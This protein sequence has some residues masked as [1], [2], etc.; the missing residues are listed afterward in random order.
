MNIPR[1]TI[2]D[3]PVIRT[4]FRWSSLILL[5]IF[6]WRFEGELPD[7]P[8]YVLIAAPHTS[9]WDLFYTMLMAI[10]KNARIYWFGKN[11]IFYPPYGFFFR[12]LGGISIDRSKPNNVVRQSI[13][14]FNEQE[15]FILTVPP[16]GTRRKVAYWKSGFYYIALGARVP[17]ALG[18]LDYGRKTAG[19]GPLFNVTGDIEAD[20]AQISDYYSNV[21]AKY[22]AKAIG[23]ATM[24]NNSANFIAKEPY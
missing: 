22:P 3:I 21:T 4:L 5:R 15:N 23:L 14:Y 24:V 1:V 18:Y 17:V 7:I 19:V 2:Y 12:W 8:K 6:G 16:S 10:S 9:A 11:S 20:M 13:E